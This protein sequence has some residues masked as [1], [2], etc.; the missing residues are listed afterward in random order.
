[1]RGAP[2]QRGASRRCDLLIRT[3]AYRMQ[4]LTRGSWSKATQRKLAA[5]T[6]Q[7][8]RSEDECAYRTQGRIRF[9]RS[10][11]LCIIYLL[12]PPERYSHALDPPCRNS[13]IR[14][15]HRPLR[16]SKL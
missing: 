10:V 7:Q 3:I 9:S 5:L 12:L 14:S 16:G 1:M 4:E 2:T 6:W 15:R 11:L 8:R 13:G